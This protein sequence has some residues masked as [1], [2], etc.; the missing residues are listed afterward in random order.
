A[1]KPPTTILS[2]Y[3]KAKSRAKKDAENK[4][5]QEKTT[6]D[7]SGSS[8]SKAGET[9]EE[10]TLIQKRIQ[11]HKKQLCSE[12]KYLSWLHVLEEDESRR[13]RFHRDIS[14]R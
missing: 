6:E 2:T 11:E 9:Q 13:S 4:T 7:A 1:V 12:C 5:N 8:S 14:I 10:S 3:A